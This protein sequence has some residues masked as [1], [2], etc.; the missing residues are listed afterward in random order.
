MRSLFAYR[1]RSSHRCRGSLHRCALC[2][3]PLAPARDL[4]ISEIVFDASFLVQC[5]PGSALTLPRCCRQQATLKAGRDP[6][7]AAAV[8][9][10]MPQS[11]SK[12]SLP[13]KA[14]LLIL[15]GA[16]HAQKA[17]LADL[18]V[19]VGQVC[20]IEDLRACEKV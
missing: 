15:C 16:A 9:A 14:P 4:V 6:D 7:N 8:H 17:A 13:A 11:E 18:L 2:A 20:S 19:K 3:Q 10:S 5:G 1:R 12:Q